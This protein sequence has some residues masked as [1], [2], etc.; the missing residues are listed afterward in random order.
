MVELLPSKYEA[1]NSS[2]STAKKKK[3]KRKKKAT[4]NKSSSNVIGCKAV[5]PSASP[6]PL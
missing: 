2:C 5:V 6:D 3:R 1:L 4:G